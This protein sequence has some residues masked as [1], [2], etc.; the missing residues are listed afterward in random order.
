MSLPI[1][2]ILSENAT[3]VDPSRCGTRGANANNVPPNWG[4]QMKAPIP[5]SE[6][7]RVRALRNYEVLDTT[8]EQAFDDLTQLA[9]QICQAPIAMISL[10]D[11][12]RQWFKSRIGVDASETSRDIAFCAHG[13]LQSDVFVVPDALAD[14]RFATNPLVTTDPKIRFY[15]GAPLVT[16]GGHR[17][18]MLCVN[19]R[20]PR[21]LSASQLDALRSLSRQAVTQLELRRH[22]ADLQRAEE[23]LH[24]RT[25]LLQLQQVVASTA[26]EASTI[27]GAMQMALDLVCAY[28]GWQVGHFLICRG[29]GTKKLIPTSVWYVADRERYR[30]FQGATDAM[31]FE[32][33]GGLPGMVMA[34]RGPVWIHN[35]PQNAKCS[36]AAV[37]AEVGIRDG[38]AL[39]VW[40]AT[41]AAAGIEFFS[42]QPI[43]ASDRLLQVVSYVAMQVGRV[44]ERKNAE[45]ALARSEERFRSE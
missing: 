10:V 30:P 13:I 14:K 28:T 41:E 4:A 18:G 25:D 38:C 12:H 9:A 3:C 36:R 5:E 42:D 29:N 45:Q 16:P 23:S 19:D 31:S 35:L 2:R 20:V 21:E 37:A 32:R 44:I 34:K 40:V 11:E 15:A 33:E 6:P 43:H 1:I 26:N 17:I 27:E 39:P 22:I 8:P 7:E 24:Q